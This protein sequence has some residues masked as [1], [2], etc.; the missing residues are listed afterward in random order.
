MKNEIKY[1]Q[2]INHW[3][4]ILMDSHYLPA[5]QEYKE[6]HYKGKMVKIIEA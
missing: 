2:L 4:G 6:K 5:L 1:Y 3:G